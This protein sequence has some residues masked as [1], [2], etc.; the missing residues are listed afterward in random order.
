MTSAFEMSPRSSRAINSPAE[1]WFK[2]ALIDD[3]FAPSQIRHYIRLLR[4]QAKPD[5][6]RSSDGVRPSVL[7]K[8]Q[9]LKKCFI[10]EKKVLDN[11]RL[12][13]YKIR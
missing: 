1:S 2:L 5:G 6:A 7:D 9:G 10:C 11:F 4:Q 12:F 3:P 8:K 13:S